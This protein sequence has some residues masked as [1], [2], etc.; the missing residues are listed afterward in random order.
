[1]RGA[2]LCAVVTAALVP[3]TAGA[4]SLMLSEAEALSRL[5][6]DSPRVRA[7]RAGI[8]LGRV[9]VLSAERWPNPRFTLDREAVA[10]ITEYLTM[11]SQPLPV[12]GRR[13][14]DADAARAQVSAIASRADDDVRRLRADLR[15]AFATLVAAQERVREL[16]AARDRLQEFVGVLAK[17]E[18]AGDAA[19]FDRLRA[20]REALDLEADLDLTQIERGH[21][22]ARLAGFFGGITDASQIVAVAGA[23][24]HLPVP[25]LES[26]V[27]QASSTRGELMA[28]Q[29][30]IDAAGFS[31][32]AAD[33]RLVP[34]PE[35]VAGTKSST[36]GTGDIGSV[37]TVHASI[38]L[39]D[40]SRPEHALAAAR[41]AQAGARADAFRVVLRAEVASWRQAVIQRRESAERYRTAA[42]GGASQVERIA[43]VSYDAGERGILELLD[44]YRL[45]S[46]ARIRQANL[47]LGVRQAEIELEFATGWEA[48][49]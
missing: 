40:H 6:S 23:P 10:G 31:A 5:S 29:H 3:S 43:R 27:A 32:R 2:L 8:D 13:G 21:A 42:V 39:F 15:V 30:E 48:S 12:T 19:G 17:R 44:A 25:E 28:L 35:I 45:G 9:D 36:A 20:E 11:V 4:Q 26:L 49:K 41:A 37:F 24:Q 38:P 34:E 22:Q 47:D 16:T 33:R 46:S 1:M 14:L 18:A 7:I